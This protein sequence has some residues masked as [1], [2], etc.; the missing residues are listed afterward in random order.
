MPIT[1]TL[2][3]GTVN[4]TD[5]LRVSYA[6]VSDPTTEVFVQ[7]IDV[8][9][10][11]YTLIVPN[12]EP[13]N[14]L[15]SFRDAPTNV[16]LGT[17]VSQ[18]FYNALTGEFEYERRF[19]TIGALPIGVSNT[20]NVLTDPYLMNKN[21]TGLFKEGFRYLEPTAEFAHDSAAGT[22]TLITGEFSG[23][24]KWMA[25]IKYN[26]G[27]SGVTAAA[28]L[29]SGTVSVTAATYSVLA[30]DKSKRHSLDC[31]GT[32]QLVTMCPLSSVATGDYFYFEH[33]RSGVQA[34]SRIIL[35]GTD[36][37][38]FNGFNLA[39][40]QLT[41]LWVS[42]GES[43]YLRKEGSFWEVIF[44]YAGTRVGEQ[45]D[46]TFLNHP[47]YLPENGVLCDG[48]EYPGLYWWIKNVMP[49]AQ[50]IIDDNVINPGYTHPGNK[51]GM[52]VIHSTLRK[53]RLPNTQG[54]T[55]KGLKDFVTYGTD[56]ERFIDQPGGWQ[57][58]QVKEYTETV[59]D[60]EG[61][62]A[63]PVGISTGDTY[64]GGSFHFRRIKRNFGLKAWVE[65]IG[66]IFLRRI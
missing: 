42:K 12:L 8:P 3:L 43:L 38:L 48:D 65:N 15:V 57:D 33:K 53:F 62:A 54:L 25:E 49:V 55:K 40:N 37:I 14:Y 27:T 24:E 1:S 61:A 31:A 45:R 11:S 32:K 56:S 16:A 9:V 13:T 28:G 44:D 46:A 66:V 4:Y 21:V 35:P 7:Y 30:A 63:S 6:K 10:T 64:Q 19:Y 58:G 36:K 20:T 41:E 2:V 29:F 51:Q 60:S 52:F 26:T 34:Q 23:G 22:E 17:L 5:W 47:N 50:K 18:A 39:S 59:G